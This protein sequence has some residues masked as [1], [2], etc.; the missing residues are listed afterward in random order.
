VFRK[1]ASQ[2]N[3]F[4]SLLALLLVSPLFDSFAG[5]RLLTYATFALILITGPVTVAPTRKHLSFSLITGILLFAPGFFGEVAN[6]PQAV[7]LST[8][9]GCVFFVHTSYLLATSLLFHIDDVDDKT[10]WAAVNVYLTIGL[11]FAFFYA[12]YAMVDSD[13]FMGKFVG[14][15]LLTQIEGFIY[16]SFVSMT[17]VGYGDLTPNSAFVATIAYLQAILGQLYVAIMIARLVGLHIS[18]NSK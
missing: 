14:E 18:A 17:T 6:N 1:L 2:R 8:A 9:F 12:T 4:L 3:L 16:F 15:D 7:M 11:A 5:S 13:A 10:L